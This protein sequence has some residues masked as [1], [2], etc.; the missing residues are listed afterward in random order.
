M[1]PPVAFRIFGALKLDAKIR[2]RS[3]DAL[4][5][6]RLFCAAGTW[7]RLALCW[8]RKLDAV[9]M[10]AYRRILGLFRCPEGDG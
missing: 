10:T 9:R 3:A 7:D 2:T 8:Q 5:F 1:Q 6:S 4:L